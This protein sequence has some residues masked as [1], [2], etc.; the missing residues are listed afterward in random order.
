[1]EVADIGGFLRTMEGAIAATLAA[2]GVTARSRHTEG[3]D[4][5]GVW[6]RERKIASIG[7]HLSRGIATHGFAVNVDNDLEPFSWIVACGLPDVGMTSL[8]LELGAPARSPGAIA[9][10]AT[11]ER[12]RARISES[13]CRAHARRARWVSPAELGVATANADRGAPAG[14]EPLEQV[15]RAELEAV[16]A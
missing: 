2:E 15:L 4:Y 11:F 13:F 7:L 8:A 6:V 3:T 5:T 12:F 16:G 9:R 14:A 10:S 1:M